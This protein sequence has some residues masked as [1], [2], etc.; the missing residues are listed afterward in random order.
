MHARLVSVLSLGLLA[1]LLAGLGWAQFPGQYPPG[2]RP[3]QGRGPQQQ[4]PSVPGRGKKSPKK[5]AAITTETEGLIRGFADKHVVIQAGDFRIVW[6]RLTNETTFRKDGKDAERA[7]FPLASHVTVESTEDD[8]GILTAVSMRFEKAGTAAERGEALR[9]WDLPRLPG[10]KTSGA[11]QQPPAEPAPPE[12]SR[13]ASG[14]DDERPTL[15]RQS[16]ASRTG[17]PVNTASKEPAKEASRDAEPFDTRPTTTIRPA[18][19]PRDDDDTG[20]PSLR[21]GVPVPKRGTQRASTSSGE[22]SGGGSPAIFTRPKEPEAAPAAAPPT[23][24]PED[25]LLQRA[26]EAAASYADTLPNFLCQQF[27]TRY[28]SENPRTGWTPLDVVSA[29]VT[30]ENG[31]ESYKNIKIN[32]KAVTKSMDDIGGSRSTGEF[33][34]ILLDIFSPDTAADFRRAGADTIAKR[35]AVMYRFQVKRE[36]S[37]WRIESPSQLYF[38]AISG[39]L[40][41]DSETARVLRIE[42]QSK[43]MPQAFPFDTTETAVDYDFVK[44]TTL[45]GFLLP[46]DAEVLSCQRGSNLCSRN[47][48][49]FR[50]YRKFGAESSISFEK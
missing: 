21:R 15:K 20:P 14:G 8:E 26:I 10:L 31:K 16:G 44:L 19:P 13:R 37:H 49:E 18:D 23:A 46:V 47:R 28:Q 5:E 29:D 39:T 42:M 2:R 50:N 30:Y 33:S 9:N 3:G 45:Q 17:D 36:N 48:I 41:I 22:S 43:G 40:W 11:A 1:V 12:P 34:S 32:S 6:F 35:S 27:T 7:E 24:P 38:P 4:P 25:K